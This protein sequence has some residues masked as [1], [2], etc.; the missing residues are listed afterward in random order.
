MSGPVS[1][2]QT[3]GGCRGYHVLVPKA[4]RVVGVA[5]ASLLFALSA[6]S[7]DAS[8]IEPWRITAIHSASLAVA[9]VVRPESAAAVPALHEQGVEVVMM[10]DDAKS[11][12]DAVA[13]ELGLD[14]VFADVLQ[15]QKA[16]N[17]ARSWRGD[18]PQGSNAFHRR[19]ASSISTPKRGSERM[20]EKKG[21]Y[22]ARNG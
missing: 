2:T 9:D 17:A 16:G 12:A 20:L 14:T 4:A 22:C 1:S 8:G 3:R 10:T 18:S 5:T 15:E 19:R 13:V 11:V 7:A 21:S 6:L